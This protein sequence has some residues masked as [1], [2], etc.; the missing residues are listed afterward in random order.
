MF[1]DNNPLFGALRI[2]R[3]KFPIEFL[4]NDKKKH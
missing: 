3:K 1:E 2:A 4:I